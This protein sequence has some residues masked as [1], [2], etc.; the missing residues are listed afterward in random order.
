MLKVVSATALLHKVAYP[1]PEKWVGA[2]EAWRAGTLSGATA[3][4]LGDRIGAVEAGRQADLVIWNLDRI[5]FVPLNDALQQLVFA[6]DKS[7]VESVIV[8]GRIVVRNGELTSVDEAALV[9]EIRDEHARLLPAIERVEQQ[10]RQYMPHYRRIYDRCLAHGIPR[11][12]YPAWLRMP[13][14]GDAA[15][16]GLS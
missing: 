5:P 7:C 6:G 12:T 15:D 2:V 14:G 16:S 10:A 9:A 3:L 13:S 1:E 4:G 11:G 8:D